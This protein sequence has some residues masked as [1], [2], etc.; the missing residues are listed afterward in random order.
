M[1]VNTNFNAQGASSPVQGAYAQ[2]AAGITEQIVTPADTSGNAYATSLAVSGVANLQ[3]AAYRDSLISVQNGSKASAPG[4]GGTIVSMT[5]GTAGLWEVIA[6]VAIS[7]T[8]VATA[9][10][11][12][13]A[14]NVGTV[15]T[16]S[17]ITYP[18]Q[19]TTGSPTV[20][21]TPPVILNLGTGSVL[22]V[23]AVGAATAGSVYAA[24]LVARKVG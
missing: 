17:P 15:A 13:F 12:N 23:T 2:P 14:L 22:L 8:T 1:A 16:I 20:G 3:T 19:S 6:Q 5:P 7:G 11:N 24:T 10:S 18:V 21:T 4:A 9:D